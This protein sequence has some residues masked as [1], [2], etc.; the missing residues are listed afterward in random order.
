MQVLVAYVSLSAFV[1]LALNYIQVSG[2]LQEVVAHS[3]S[4][5]STSDMHWRLQ[6]GSLLLTAAN[7][8]RIT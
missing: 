1:D 2:Y 6:E 3:G 8:R 4:L 5:A 7:F